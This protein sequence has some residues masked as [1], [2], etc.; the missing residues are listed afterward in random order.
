MNEFPLTLMVGGVSLSRMIIGI[1]WFLGW[2]HTSAAKDRFI[3]SYQ[4]RSN[5]ADILTVF[6]EHGIDTIMGLP[7]PPLP[8]GH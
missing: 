3:K 1:N 2:S 5:I 6:L 4:T 8:E 7:I